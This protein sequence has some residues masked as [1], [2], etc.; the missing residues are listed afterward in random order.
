MAL[1]IP[2]IRKYMALFFIAWIAFSMHLDACTG[3][4]LV[5]KDNSYVNGR[6]LEF[7]IQ[8]DTSAVIIP[9]GYSFVGTTPIGQGMSYQSKYACV[10]AITFDDISILDGINE[11][12][13]T[14]G[15]FYFPGF[16]K[17]SQINSE[18]LSK[19][20]SPLEFPNWIV[21]QFATV[22]EVK[23]ALAN[24]TIA[25]TTNPNWGS[26]PPPLHYIVYDKMGK[27]LVI[28]PIDGQLKTYDNKLGV[29]TNSPSFDWHM[30]NLRNFINLTTFSANPVTLSGV[31]L[32]PLGQGSG[33]VGLPGD[34]TSPSRF[35][36]AAI[37][38]ATAIPPANAEDAVFQ[39]FHILN[40]FD[41]PLGA[42]REK[43][44]GKIYTDYTM[45]TSVK[46]PQSLKY[47]FKTYEDQSIRYIDLNKFDWNAKAVKK[48]RASGNE[49]AID[50]SSDLI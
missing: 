29:F 16:A 28:E 2:K 13:L 4:K 34:F 32:S 26:M 46:D 11:K 9:R 33:M 39:A 41:I 44:N 49:P 43:N 17:Y 37:F 35:V 45:I 10:G 5:A 19:A 40:Q 25:E 8:L 31:S 47:Y 30:T 48:A 27:C 7:G 6:T 22:E 20:L 1:Y 12:G 3:I 50:V 14:V 38:S 24:V 36:R 21:S 15:T 42:S 23:A 18:N